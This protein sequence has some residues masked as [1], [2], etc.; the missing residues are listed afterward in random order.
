MQRW[1]LIFFSLLLLLLTTHSTH[2]QTSKSTEKIPHNLMAL[3]DRYS[4]HL[5]QSTAPSFTS[6][7]PSVR[8][9]DDYVVVDAVASGDVENLKADL[10]SLGMQGAVAYGRMVSGYLPISSIPTASALTSLKF[11]QTAKAVTHVGS[12]TSQGDQSM[13]SNVTRAAFAVDGSGIKV[14]VLSDS[15]DCLGGA[16]TDVANG[17]LSSVTIVQEISSCTDATDEGRAMLQIIHDVAPGAGLS[18]ASA[19]NGMAS[20]AA[21]ITALKNNGAKVIVD[22]IIY[23]AEPMFQDGIVAQAVDGVV[24]SDAAY[25]S[26]AGNQARQSYQSAFRPGDFFANGA[27]PSAPGAPAFL[28]GTG[29]NFNSIGGKDQ[30]LS[31]TIPGGTGVTVV[32][33]WDSPFFSVSGS[34][35]TQNDL[36]LYVLDSSATQV[37][38]GTTFNNIGG[39]AVEIFGATNTGLAALN[40]NLMIVNHSGVAP[41]L[42]KIVYFY[43]GAP[44]IINEFD[45]QSGTIY[46]HA[47]ASG[48]EAVGAARYSNT[49]AFGVS[50]PV[51]ESF[52]SSGSTPILFDLTG[53]RL[54]TPDPRP[55]KPEIVAP[56][57]ADTTFFGSFDFDGTGFPNFFGTSAAAPHVAGVAALLLQAK[58]TLTPAK[59]YRS[60][61]NTAID[62]DVAGFDNNSG[63]GFVQADAALAAA[64]QPTPVDFDGDGESEI[65]VY[66]GGA[67]LFHDF[68]SGAH[69]NGVWS[70]GGAGCIPA[71]MDYDGDGTTDFAQLCN[72]AWHLYNNDGS[73]LK[74]I[75]TGG[76][77]GDRPAPGDYDGDG[78]DDIVVYRG[79]AWL[80]YNFT[81][82]VWDAAKSRWTGG[83]IGCIPAPMDY[84]GDGTADFTQLCNGG[85]HFYNDD[86]SY[87]KGIWTGGVLG[88]LPVPADYDGDG[89]DDVVV[90]RGGAWLFFDFATG[91]YDA[92]KSIWTGALPHWT[93]GTSLPAP[94]DYD[95]DGKADFTV[96]SGGPWHFYNSNGTYNKGLWTGGIAGDQVLSRR[97]LP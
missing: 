67:W 94:L 26:S 76:V 16:A 82:G 57:G 29:H 38:A 4:S 96:Y 65:G 59:V 9:I 47:N 12:V 39:D 42:L 69:T 30:F 79:G 81:T 93:G 64:L 5:A 87:N 61:E 3:Y 88:D 7:D 32:L 54:A 28:G 18:F 20:F 21:N 24:A 70:G 58:P 74:G 49:P 97:L 46:G 10:T 66:R 95:G 2:A 14:G 43:S 83:G 55:D 1:L 6:D 68:A 35:G 48:G 41:G 34:P 56:D 15:F 23:L 40:V 86:G 33:Q 52:S 60:L 50:P 75:W 77:A 91:A 25:F 72:G 31:V 53:N 36:D 85:W 62:M 80:F 89:I 63:F 71:P 27:I 37:L 8:Q 45:T 17:D 11:V 84:D 92:A 51:L 90:F 78:T 22:D 19:F 73:Y 13:R 44:P